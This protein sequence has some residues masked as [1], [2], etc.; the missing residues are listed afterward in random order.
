MTSSEHHPKPAPAT[1]GTPL[2]QEPPETGE[3]PTVGSAGSKPEAAASRASFNAEQDVAG[4]DDSENDTGDLEVG[5]TLRPG[6]HV[7]ATP[8]GNLGDMTS[9]AART[10]TEADVVACEDTRV[11]GSLL[12]LLGLKARAL[13][14][15]HDHNADRVRPEILA[16]LAA[17]QVVALV[18]DAGTPL[19]SDP[20]FRLV[21]DVAEAG[22][23]VYAVPGA[24]A[25]LSALAV[26][27]LP[28]DRFLFAG[29]LP[30]KEGAR[31]T[32]LAEVAR[33]P[34]TLVFYES[35]RRLADVLPAMQAAFGD[36]LAAVCRELTKRHEEVRRGRLSDLAAQYAAEPTP[37]GEVVVV[38]A[39]PG[40][41]QQGTT[42]E[43]IDAALRRA[44]SE[45]LSV[46]DAAQTVAVATGRP[47]REVY[48][49]ALALG[50]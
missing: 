1:P 44:L 42:D 23:G 20:G 29:F 48:A 12:S 26:A 13:I 10:L 11:T 45:G 3:Q 31:A 15:Y 32:A 7:V 37:K 43:D 25:L 46:R 47:R 40:E 4:D 2:S 28:T 22:F 38:I 34:A 14:A 18:S 27:G 24:S 8:I 33:V 39:P 30:V 41:E 50:K 17:G 35:P 36:R 19:V 49:R 6:L 21:R 16:R 5:K 9:R